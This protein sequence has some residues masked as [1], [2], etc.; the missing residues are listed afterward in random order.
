MG[1]SFVETALRSLGYTNY[2]ACADILDNSID[3]DAQNIY[4]E[5]GRD[6]TD[7]KLVG[8]ISISDDGSGMNEETLTSAM[9]LS[10]QDGKDR[11]SLGY[12]GAGLKTAALSIGRRLTVY[13][14]AEN[15]P[16]FKAILDIDQINTKDD[17]V[18]IE[19]GEVKPDSDEYKNFVS[20]V[21]ETGTIIKIEKL[22]R[23]QNKDFFGF[24]GTLSK[25]VRILF[26]KYIESDA[27][28]FFV[29]G[30]KLTYF[31][32]IG[33][34]FLDAVLWDDGDFD[35]ENATIK[36][37]AW[38]IPAG[39]AR[40]KSVEF[41]DAFGRTKSTCGIYVYRNNRMVG[42]G[43][44]LGM[45]Q[46]DGN[47]T[48]GLRFE[49][50]LD[51]EADYLFGTTFTKM[52]TEKEKD[53]IIDGFY[54]KLL[55]VVKPQVQRANREQREESKNTAIPEDLDKTLKRTTEIANQN[56]I[57]ASMVKQ[58]GKNNKLGLS[59]K[60]NPNPK[61]QENPNPVKKR[62]GEWF[63]GFEFH[64]DGVSGAMFETEHRLGKAYVIINKDH[65]FYTCIFSKLDDEGRQLMALYLA[66]EYPALVKSE[67]YSDEDGTQK[68]I[69]YY[70]ENYSD[71]VRRAFM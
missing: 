45:F 68:S 60:K 14:K 66:C 46:K 58:K 11:L 33:S 54:D 44:D 21:S 2:T 29:N 1:A 56:K 32:V 52:I 65:A 42:E 22:D 64:S 3:A 26:N 71:A 35:Y 7:K 34:Q 9:S 5:V 67:Y 48:N 4:I 37:K 25:K 6:S 47:R 18:E 41:K 31:D 17:C 20:K 53:G 61:P 15:S 19:I 36:W 69:R 59:K 63:G 43:L 62:T 27:V 40:E 28:S 51:G 30:E 70:K 57:L 13:T 50:F 55:N 12:Y 38:Y 49:L 23:I 10:K 16:L 39:K 8:S 24:S